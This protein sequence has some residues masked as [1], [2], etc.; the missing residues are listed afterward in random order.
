MEGYIALL[1]PLTAIVLSLSIPIVAIIRSIMR[2]RARSRERLLAI[3]KGVDLTAITL[4]PPEDKAA[5]IKEAL[6]KRPEM[7]LRNGIICF[8]VGLAFIGI[9]IFGH[10]WNPFGLMESAGGFSYIVIAAGLIV[11][12][13][14]IAKILW[15]FIAKKHFPHLGKDDPISGTTNPE[16]HKE[17]DI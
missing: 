12:L 7:D 1:I 15:F 5:M 3:E 8:F 10:G 6:R 11:G 2:D 17:E 13:I 16:F 14:G 4:D 9:A